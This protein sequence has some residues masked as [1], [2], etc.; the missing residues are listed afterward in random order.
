[1]GSE[2][3]PSN[4]GLIKALQD[5]PHAFSFFQVIQLL[6]RYL[7]GAGVGGGSSAS[8]ER[9][10]LKPAVSMSFPAADL[11]AIEADGEESPTGQRFRI[12]TSFL[13]LYSSDSPLPTF[14]TED[15]FWKENDQKAVRDFVDLFHHRALSLFYRAWEKYRHTVQFRHQ[16][17]DEYSR[18]VY[19]LIG[20]G[21]RQLIESTGLPSVRLL[22]Y[23]GLITRKPHSASVLSGILKDYFSLPDFAVKQCVER[24]ARVDASQQNRLGMENCAL[25]H[26]LTI[27]ARVRDLGSKFRV[28]IGPLA[29][30]D[31]LRFLPV[32]KDYAALINL[33]RFY[34]TDRLDFDVEVKLRAEETPPLR[35]S[36]KSPVRLSWTSCLSLPGQNP[37]VVLRQPVIQSPQVAFPWRGAATLSPAGP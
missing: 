30:K 31:Y 21:T 36:S 16:G 32:S 24:W 2:T 22:Q 13:G 4:S 10:R 7:G 20:L 18:R 17:S 23:A 19:S 34:I 28:E 14:C 33:I 29:L 11:L 27:G 6:Q 35:L 8:D 37:S 15:L 26:N 3:R 5:K 25:G 9:L 12:T 1:M